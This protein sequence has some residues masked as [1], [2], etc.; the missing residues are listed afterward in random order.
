MS[1]PR[2]ARPSVGQ[3]RLRDGAHAVTVSAAGQRV[4]VRAEH[5]AGLLDDL[6][7]HEEDQ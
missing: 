7:E 6:S 3:I 5:L 2:L 1:T 4:I